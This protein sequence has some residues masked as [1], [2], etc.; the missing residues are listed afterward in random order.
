LPIKI[1][2]H[3]TQITK[4][5]LPSIE[6]LYEGNLEQAAKLD[7]LQALLNS[8][9]RQEWVKQHPMAKKADGTPVPYIPIEVTEYL[10]KRIFKRYRIEVINTSTFF[11][12][13]AVTIR[14]HY[15]NPITGEWDFHDG[16]GAVDVQTK[17]GASPADLANINPGAVQKALPAA[18]SYA[19]KDACDHLG[20]LFG[21][22][23]GRMSSLGF[24]QNQTFAN[25]RNN[26]GSA[27]IWLQIKKANTMEQLAA[28]EEF[29]DISP[30]QQ[31]EIENK[32][33]TI[34]K[35]IQ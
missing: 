1:Q 4:P 7:G 3:M 11:N 34:T 21:A 35:R 26:A 30:E 28:I 15:L 10:L 16:V 32:K 5:Q 14:V 33:S 12:S 13:I 17:K 31:A 18:K 24:E 27:S 29:P 23:I 6:E 22:N 2:S 9:P 25:I 8:N 19:I 20:N